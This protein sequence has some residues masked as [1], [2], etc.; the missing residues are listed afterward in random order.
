MRNHRDRATFLKTFDAKAI[1]KQ[2]EVYV[3]HKPIPVTSDY[4]YMKTTSPQP[5]NSTRH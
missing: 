2:I 1:K 3:G 4:I 5:P